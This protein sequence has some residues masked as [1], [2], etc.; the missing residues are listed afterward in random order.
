MNTNEHESSVKISPF[1]WMILA[2]LFM[3][4]LLQLSRQPGVVGAGA[5]AA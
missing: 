3:Q 4:N 5:G 1:R 2:L